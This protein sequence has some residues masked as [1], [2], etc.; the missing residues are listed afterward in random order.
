MISDKMKMKAISP[1]FL[2][3]KVFTSQHREEKHRALPSLLDEE[4]EIRR[5]KVKAPRICGGESS[6]I[7]G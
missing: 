6:Q 2:P 7:F 3:R 1:S 5:G 4:T